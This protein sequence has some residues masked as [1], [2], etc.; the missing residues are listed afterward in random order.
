MRYTMHISSVISTVTLA[1]FA[2]AAVFVEGNGVT[3]V[4]ATVEPLCYSVP[5]YWPRVGNWIDACRVEDPSC[6]PTDA[7]YSKTR[8]V[9][10]K[11]YAAELCG[12]N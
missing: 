8:R 5:G 4:P 1:S 3:C 11:Y 6:G 10:C 2:S 9:A 7:I 12:K